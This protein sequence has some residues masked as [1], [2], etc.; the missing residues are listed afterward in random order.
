MFGGQTDGQPFLGDL[1]ALDPEAG[2]WT[3][4]TSEPRPSPRNFYAMAETDPGRIV[5]FGGN[6]D[7]GP[8]P[9]N[10]LWFF[11]CATDTWT[12]AQPEGEAPSARYGHDAV[13]M[14]ESRRFI[15]FGGHD[16]TGDLNDLWELTIP[17]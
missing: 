9:V 7:D 5:L 12:L 15:V 3:E 14:A 1:W 16:T 10:D 13:W 8:G 17:A 11:D 4:I 6:T 2:S